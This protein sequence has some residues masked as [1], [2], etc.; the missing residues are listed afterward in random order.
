MA[1][2][3]A[4]S[5]PGAAISINGQSVS[6]ITF[7]GVH[8]GFVEVAGIGPQG[9]K[10]DQGEQGPQGEQ[11]IPGEAGTDDAFYLHDQMIAASTWN[12]THNLDK[13]PSVTVVTS[14]GDEVEGDVTYPSINTVQINFSAAFGG[15]AYL[16]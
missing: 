15:K 10:G 3:E 6:A 2:I 8:R 7:N 4:Y 9:A 12:I 13:Y 14:A 1:F 11:G 5:I 16:N